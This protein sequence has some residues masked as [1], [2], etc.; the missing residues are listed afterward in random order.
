MALRSSRRFIAQTNIKSG[1]MVEFTYTKLDST[2]SSY[3]IL[4]IDPNKNG[5]VHG[6]LIDD[7]SDQDLI[8]LVEV[9]EDTVKNKL[10]KIKSIPA[11]IIPA[12]NIEEIGSL[13]NERTAPL[14]NLQSDAAYQRFKSSEFSEDRRYRTF[15]IGK[16]SGV[17]Q[18]LIGEMK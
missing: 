11:R 9:G 14:T 5:Y 6:L 4:I 3:T 12:E 16:M 18:I 8:R 13:K 17:R 7:L 2:T 10:G 15:L 1:M